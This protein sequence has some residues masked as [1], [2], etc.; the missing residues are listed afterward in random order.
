MNDGIRNLKDLLGLSVEEAVDLA[1]IN[2][3]KALKVDDKK[4]SIA[5]GKDADFAVID[6]DFNVYMTV[7]KGEVVYSKF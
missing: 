6:K 1:S 2:P 4:G 7:V 5:L 3:A